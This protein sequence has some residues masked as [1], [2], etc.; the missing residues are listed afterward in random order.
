MRMDAVA[1]LKRSNTGKQHGYR[2][3]DRPQQRWEK[4]IKRTQ[5]VGNMKGGL[6]G[7]MGVGE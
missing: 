2:K 6:M 5:K 7:A 4:Y 1:L 3:G